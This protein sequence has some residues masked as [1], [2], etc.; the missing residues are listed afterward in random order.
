MN[1]EEVF[2]DDDARQAWNEAARAWEEFVESG[3]DYY[4]HDVHSPA[5]LE[6]CEPVAGL[7][8][9]DLGCGQGHFSRELARRGARVVA[10][11]IAEEM[12]AYARQHEAREPLGIEYRALNATEVDHH[13]PAGSFDLVTAC[14][15]LHDI[16]Q[17]GQV[18]KSAF[19][20]LRGGGRL[21]FSIPHPCTDT[22]F[23]E[24]EQDQAGRKGA[25]RID[26]YFD[27][28]PTVCHWRMARL[29]Y[30]WDT[31][32]WHYT[33][34]EWSEMIA[35]AGFLVRRLSEPRPT[36]EQIERTPY[37]ED[38]YRLPCFLIFD[39]VKVVDWSYP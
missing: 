19:E 26:R 39:L 15:A 37:I 33:L 12:L 20:V 10:I 21:A 27:S 1:R 16:A 2:R 3:A 23:R 9:L 6:M 13:W 7:R 30:H 36:R 29:S 35:V 34:S 5:L 24:W 11:D 38:A 17:P 14:M 25:L 31:P 8:V 4:R 28:G 22:P 18:L 32:Y